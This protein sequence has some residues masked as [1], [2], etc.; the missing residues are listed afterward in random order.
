MNR[1]PK[2]KKNN[3]KMEMKQESKRGPG[4]PPKGKKTDQLRLYIDHEILKAWRIMCLQR[5]LDQPTALEEALREQMKSKGE[6]K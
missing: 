3:M 4:R 6:K 5:E 2:G 1:K